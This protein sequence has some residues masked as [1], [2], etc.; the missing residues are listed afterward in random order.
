MLLLLPRIGFYL[1]PR[2]F[3]HMQSYPNGT[4]HFA[5]CL[6]PQPFLCDCPIDEAH[7]SYLPYAWSFVWTRS[8]TPRQIHVNL[9]P[10]ICVFPFK[11][12]VHYS[13][14]KYSHLQIFGF[15]TLASSIL[16]RQDTGRTLDPRWP[17]FLRTKYPYRRGAT[18]RLLAVSVAS[19]LTYLIPIL[20]ESLSNSV[21]VPGFLCL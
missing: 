19:R 21:T 11:S 5:F 18:V 6:A 12:M 2:A 20:L 15:R 8:R 4:I 1:L 10:S 17:I 14:G 16:F 13:I 9:V 3:E 7:V